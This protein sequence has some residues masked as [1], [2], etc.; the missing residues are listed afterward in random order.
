MAVGYVVVIKVI[1]P[2]I[3]SR[4]LLL[5]GSGP[6]NSS[7]LLGPSIRVPYL[8]SYLAP[9]LLQLLLG[10]CCLTQGLLVTIVPLPTCWRNSLL[11]RTQ[12]ELPAPRAGIPKGGK[13]CPDLV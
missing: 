11:S 1:P 8:G 13:F 10:F 4:Y 6:I 5:P 2:C 9:T 12:P 7:L 3:S